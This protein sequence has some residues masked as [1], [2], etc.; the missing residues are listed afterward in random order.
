[1]DNQFVISAYHNYLVNGFLVAGFQMGKPGKDRFFFRA[2][3]FEF[4][5]C[6]PQPLISA[7][8]FDSMGQPLLQIDNGLVVQNPGRLKFKKTRSG[9][10]IRTP[11]GDP[12]FSS[13][14]VAF[15]N[16]YYTRF[17]GTLFDEH[18]ELM[19]SGAWKD[20]ATHASI[21]VLQLGQA[22]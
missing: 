3:P 20:F 13:E 21:P 4:Q 12:F 7:N 16:S 15:R 18:G 11:D 19:A 9:L 1:M 6:E 5:N 17:A 2:P 8:L 14:T 22:T 10:S